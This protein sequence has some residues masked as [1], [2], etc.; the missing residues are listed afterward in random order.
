MALEDSFRRSYY[1]KG[2][3]GGSHAATDSGIQRIRKG[4]AHLSPEKKQEYAYRK[5][6]ADGKQEGLEEGEKRGFESANAKFESLMKALHQALEQLQSLHKKTARELEREIVELSLAIAR[7]VVCRETTTDREIVLAVARKALQQLENPGIIK[8]KI[9][10][11]DLQAA[12]EAGFGF[13]DLVENVKAIRVEAEAA[14][15]AGGCVIETD[16]GEI[17]ARIDQ[18]LQTVEAAFRNEMNRSGVRS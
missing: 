13:G 7:K 4:V 10:P 14:I 3:S 11:A 8:I 6:F 16:C 9:N 1:P 2:G 5:G 12:E 17:D 18:Q 15:E